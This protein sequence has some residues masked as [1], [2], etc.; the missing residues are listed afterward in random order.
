MFA[1]TK[2]SAH[3]KADPPQGARNPT[4]NEF[5]KICRANLSFRDLFL[6]TRHEAALWPADVPAVPSIRPENFHKLFV[7]NQLL[8]SFSIRFW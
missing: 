8:H 1:T 3:E 5:I 2:V 6:A 7:R 4:R